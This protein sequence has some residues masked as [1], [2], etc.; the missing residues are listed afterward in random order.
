M[1][2]T[3]REL[4]EGRERLAQW[5]P[6]V[7]A[8]I[9]LSDTRESMVPTTLIAQSITA[10]LTEKNFDAIVIRRSRGGWHA[11][12]LLRGMPTGLSDVLGT[13]EAQPLASRE[14]AET[15]AM[16]LFRGLL[17]VAMENA[18]A[19]RDTPE[20]DMRPFEIHGM[21]IGVPGVIVDKMRSMGEALGP[22]LM[23]DAELTRGRLAANLVSMFGSDRFDPD[24]WEGATDEAR[25][26]ILANIVV[27]LALGENRHP[28]RFSQDPLPERGDDPAGDPDADR[29]DLP[30]TGLLH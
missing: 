30:G 18:R 11:D 20:V 3:R 29:D 12:I 16:L 15:A 14:A 6:R 21:T 27:L 4:R 25:R 10:R 19:R 24:I 2:F 8:Q 23:G 28:A 22:A 13:P 7:R 26:R 5:L 1:R 9:D 17:R